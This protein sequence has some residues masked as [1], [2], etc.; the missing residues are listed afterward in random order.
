MKYLT[1][2]PKRKQAL[3][4]QFG[5]IDAIRKASL[6]QLL[7]VKGIPRNVAENIRKNL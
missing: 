1:S 6:D 3:L 4:Q 2:G 7:S 5:S